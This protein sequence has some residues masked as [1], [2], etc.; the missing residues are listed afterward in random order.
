MNG[1][2]LSLIINVLEKPVRIVEAAA[3]NVAKFDV[4]CVVE[5]EYAKASVRF[6]ANKYS[7]ITLGY[8]FR[9]HG[10]RVRW[11]H[12]GRLKSCESGY[13]VGSPSTAVIG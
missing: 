6:G 2:P 1:I 8:D 5:T 12:V 13:R 7:S 3:E 9:S 10:A 11:L 4:H